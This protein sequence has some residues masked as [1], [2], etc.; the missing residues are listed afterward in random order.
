MAIQLESHDR[1]M[2]FPHTKERQRH[3]DRYKSPSSF[4]IRSR[5]SLRLPPPP[6]TMTLPGLAG[7][8]KCRRLPGEPTTWVEVGISSHSCRAIVRSTRKLGHSCVN[9]T[10]ES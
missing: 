6:R 5:T 2:S 7:P 10:S 8:A 4:L 9:S 3:Y 1:N